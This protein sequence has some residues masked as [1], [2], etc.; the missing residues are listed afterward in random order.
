LVVDNCEH[1]LEPVADLVEAIERSCPGVVVLAT[2]REGLSLEG[3]QNFTVPSLKTPSA[4]DLEA[5]ARSEAVSLFVE[6][7]VHADA[8]FVLTARNAT[9]VVQIC[10]QL[11]GLPLALELAA[12]RVAVMTPLELAQALERRFETLAA[13]RRRG[14]AR[15][16]TL[17]AAIDWS[18]QLGSAAEQCLLARLAV[19][20]GGWSREAAEIVCASDPIEGDEVFDLLSSLAAK[21]LVVVERCETETRYR[22]LETIREY[23]EARLLEL[24][25]PE[26]IRGR[27]AEYYVAFAG[28]VA[29]EMWGPHQV[30]A[31]LRY[32]AEHGNVVAA[33]SFA[34]ETDDVDLALR[35]LANLPSLYS[36]IG[37]E[38]R[39]PP[40]DSVLALTGAEQHA[41]YPFALAHAAVPAAAI[42][43]RTRAVA[44]AEQALSAAQGSGEPERRVEEIV[45]LR[46]GQSSIAVLAHDAAADRYRY[47][48]EVAEHG[49]RVG[50]AAFYFGSAAFEYMLAGDIDTARQVGTHGLALARLVG[51]PSAIVTNLHALAGGLIDDD[52]LEAH[53]LF[54]QALA[55]RAQLDS[56]MT[57]EVVQATLVSALLEDWSITLDS[58][59]GAIRDCHWRGDWGLLG[60]MCNIVVTPITQRDPEAAAVVQG[61]AAHFWTRAADDA[62][63]RYEES[64]QRP[65]DSGAP[66]TRRDAV[67]DLRRTA[68]SRLVDALGETRLREL[69][70][71][72]RAMDD[73]DAVAYVLDAISRA[74]RVA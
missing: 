64:A 44:L 73:D 6:R 48:A 57:I 19:F 7:A 9:A 26:P 14:V 34:I 4:M 20:V 8:D 69:R 31:C 36:E 41:L 3:E 16:Q 54:E 35:L 15:H 28:I 61:I 49:G 40:L 29:A 22:L 37:L 60:A 70:N 68:T 55:V 51:M 46:L 65:D 50:T 25:D 33:L 13:G 12:A 10:R 47:V 74:K 42:G 2:S 21:S 43:D 18:Y 23:A 1:V 62:T 24:G 58:A 67:T 63:S 39:L 59:Q 53:A 72:G 11:E 66:P 56:V 27:H 71:R 30:D 45:A 52:P 17:E 38:L 5:V 32:A